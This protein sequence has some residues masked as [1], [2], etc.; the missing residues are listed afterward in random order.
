[1]AAENP[2]TAPAARERRLEAAPFDAST[3][4]S[5]TS[6]LDGSSIGE[7]DCEGAMLEENWSSKDTSAVGL[8]GCRNFNSGRVEHVG[9]KEIDNAEANPPPTT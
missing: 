5:L 1:M 2:P 6:S 4:S 7:D 9:Y 8:G 3:T